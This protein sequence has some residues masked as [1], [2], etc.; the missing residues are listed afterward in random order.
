MEL[1]IHDQ[2]PFPWLGRV[3]IERVPSNAQREQTI[4]VGLGLGLAR[5]LLK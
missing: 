3:R 2:R 5:E 1:F 4:H